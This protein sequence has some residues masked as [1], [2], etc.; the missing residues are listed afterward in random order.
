MRTL[1]SGLALHP[2]LLGVTLALAGCAG[3]DGST[4]AGSTSGASTSAATSSSSSGG[5]SG[6]ETGG[7]GTSGGGTT[8]AGGTTSSTSG[9]ATT[10]SSSSS[11]GGLELCHFGGTG[12][13]GGSVEPWLELTHKGAPITDGSVLGLEC[14]LQ[15]LFMLEIVPYFGG[16]EPVDE[17]IQMAVEMDVDGFNLGPEGHFYKFDDFSFYAGCEL[18]DGG[19]GFI[20]PV[21]PP[22]TIDDVAALEGASGTLSV[23]LFPDGGDP[24]VVSASVKLSAVADD[25]WQFCGYMP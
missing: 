12:E 21:I 7:S 19:V 13:S 1:S 6:D 4:S 14:G 8:S 9:G 20:I 5:S 10:S 15:G 23:T 24:V 25:M 16:F 11:T 18:S 17:F 3:D 22:D 2:L